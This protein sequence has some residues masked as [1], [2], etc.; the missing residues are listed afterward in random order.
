MQIE[1]L[2]RD[3]AELLSLPEVCLQIQLL[4]D[5]PEAGMEDFARIII[6]DPAFTAQLLKRVNSAACGL[7]SRVDTVSRAVG[8]VGINELRKLAL[9]MA[10][11]EVFRGQPLQGYDM[12]T[13]WR[14]GVFVALVAQEL[15]RQAG[16][17]HAERL[18]IAGLLHD[19]GHLVMFTR[20]PD[21]CADLGP[22]VLAHAEDLCRQE[23]DLLGWDHAAL[24]GALL[25]HWQLPGELCLAAECHHAPLGL[26]Q[27]ARETALVALANQVAHAVEQQPGPAAGAEHDPYTR[28]I[29]IEDAAPVLNALGHVPM[30]LW[31]Q[32]GVGPEAV[33]GCLQQ[34]G[35][36]FD[37]LLELLYGF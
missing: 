18:F 14:H 23:R 26:G 30:A 20:M 17:L 3:N 24:G 1:Q 37:T 34:A 35:S 21:A 29:E 11:V 31:Q 25:R 27:G 7:P 13:F 33:P 22:A 28:F 9:A 16:V 32:A 36:E 6:Q 15:A 19:I 5:D 4:A 12:L 8:L 2:I 10:A